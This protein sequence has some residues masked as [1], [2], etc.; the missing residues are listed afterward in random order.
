MKTLELYIVRHCESESNVSDVFQGQADGGVTPKGVIQAQRVGARLSDV[1]FDAIY[2]SPLIRAYTT[3]SSIHAAQTRTHTLPMYS[4]MNLREINAGRLEGLTITQIERDYP[5]EYEW[6]R[7]DIAR[8]V[9]PGGESF[10]QLY[11]RVR[12]EFNVIAEDACSRGYSRVCV[13]AHGAVLYAFFNYANGFP[14]E[15]SSNNKFWVD[16]ASVSR[17][18]YDGGFNVIYL[19]DISHFDKDTQPYVMFL[20]DNARAER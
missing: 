9:A 3:A 5:A 16:N 18:Q 15:G 2:T 12:A 17:V 4:R 11:G 1:S 19:N 13:V 7:S 14:A 8:F 20:A 6:W 10:V